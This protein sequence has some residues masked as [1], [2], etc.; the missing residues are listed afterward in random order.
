MNLI[1]AVLLALPLGGKVEI[2]WKEAYK[3]I[4]PK[5]GND[6][7]GYV[8]SSN[9]D[10]DAV[11]FDWVEI[12]STGTNLNLSD[13][14]SATVT[15]PFVFKLYDDTTSTIHVQSNGG[16]TFRDIKL[17]YF[18][19]ALPDTNGTMIAVYWSDQ[20]PS[21]HGGVYY[22]AFSDTMAVI[23]WYQVPEYSGTTYNTYEV[24]LWSDGRIRLQYLDINDYSDETVGI[25]SKDAFSTGNGWFIQYV[26]DSIPDNHVPTDSSVIE[27]YPPV[28][29]DHDVGILSLTTPSVAYPSDTVSITATVKN[30]GLNQETFDVRFI[31]DTN[32]I[33][34]LD[35]TVT[36]ISLD[37]AQIT[38]V[39]V[40]YAVQSSGKYNVM[41]YT[42]LTS[43]TNY[44][45]DTAYTSFDAIGFIPLPYITDFESDS[46]YFYHN[47][48]N[49]PWQW[50]AASY[51]HSG[52]HA[53]ATA[54]TDTYPSHGDATLYTYVIDLS[55]FSIY[56]S[57]YVRFW[58]FDSL[59]TNYDYVY[60]LITDDRGNTW[61]TLRTYNGY[62]DN[63]RQEYIDL[64]SY[65]GKKVQ[66]A[67][68]FE[69]DYSLTRAGFFLDDFEIG[70]PFDNDVGIRDININPP[71]TRPNDTVE[72]NIFVH[73]FG[74]QTQNDFYT[75]Y[76]INGPGGVLL[77]D[78]A[79]ITS[80]SPSEDTQVTVYFSPSDT[81]TYTVTAYTQ[82]PTDECTGND[83]LQANFLS[84][85]PDMSLDKHTIGGDGIASPGENN[86]PLILE[87]IN[88]GARADSV[89]FELSTT[90][91][92]ISIIDP[93]HYIGQV[94]YSDTVTDT[95]FINV[96]SSAQNGDV[97]DFTFNI[98]AE[99]NYQ[100]SS[101]F[102]IILGG[103]AWTVMVLING[104]NNLTSYGVSDI[105]EMESIGSNDYLNI[106]V[107]FDG[108]SSYTDSAGSHQDANRYYIVH[109]STP[110]DMID[111]YPIMNLG[112]VD[113]GDT[114]VIFDFFK[115]G[116]DNYPA[117][118][119]LFI[120]WDH[121]SGWVKDAAVHKG[122]SHDDT[123]GDYLSFANGEVRALLKKMHDYLGRNVDILGYDVCLVQM[124]ENLYEVYGYA[125]HVVASEKPEPG[126]GWDYHFLEAIAS[127]PNIT[128]SELSSEIVNYYSQ[129]YSSHSDVTLSAIQL[130]STIQKLSGLL[131]N[132]SREL[133]KAGGIGRS[134]IQNII[135]NLD[136]EVESNYEPYKYFVDVKHFAMELKNAGINTSI[137]SICDSIIALY[138]SSAFFDNAWASSDVS[139]SM[140]G[141]SIMLPPGG[142][143]L[144]GSGWEA[145]YSGL[146]LSGQTLWYRFLMGATAL[147]DTAH[148]VLNRG[149]F[150]VQGNITDTLTENSQ[151]SLHLLISNYTN[152]PD[153]NITIIINA[154]QFITFSSETVNIP[155][156]PED[157]TTEIELPFTISPQAT[158]GGYNVEITINGASYS[159]NY[160][161]PFIIGTITTIA[162]KNNTNPLSEFRINTFLKAGTLLPVQF[163]CLKPGKVSISLFDIQG[164]K[165]KTLFE[166]Q[167][168]KGTHSVNLK[169]PNTLS[170]G[171]YFV[172]L[173]EPATTKSQRVIILK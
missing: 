18:N 88:N 24:I 85:G 34:I 122:V 15:L 172:I 67:F 164:R 105:D 8:Y 90:S 35:T 95:F 157:T 173:K 7:Y 62:A 136:G 128:P 51:V 22:Q 14:D 133:I 106:L 77:S 152:A 78:T 99:N 96:S 58:Y 43:D 70:I 104:D 111:A 158:K 139:S 21:S 169:L 9:Q 123:D 119:Y 74:L 124:L 49:D 6:V 39:S 161:V 143:G 103:K 97:A 127:N 84:G 81:G 29:Q 33:V 162:E 37:T 57:T 71:V 154:P 3:G 114:N 48:T 5:G 159:D 163:S 42:I 94:L 101:N 1:I 46:G 59:E 38:D 166:G 121:G 115:W 23:E 112:E 113:M 25:Q 27:F 148:S 76:S 131:N 116:V 89:T 50:G 55:S 145:P 134:D 44:L 132:L 80:L 45:N 93:S 117:R 61:D 91:P 108:S 19:H 54:L 146:L 142:E 138:D 92:N 170:E 12:S 72:I 63:W 150:E 31:V 73:N 13:E 60:L 32:S 130:N 140:Y 66:L 141:I 82:L 64:K 52:T 2:P 155:V 75:I 53:W 102:Q 10:G 20:N 153:T 151:G 135:N 47:G 168:Q 167:L 79:L 30:Y 147:S 109:N 100:S 86:V 11:T 137:T 87:V 165:V 83:T 16:I 126:D 56:D 125:D 41:A 156:I 40:S 65:N 110:N 160:R 107:Q 171:I 98:L 118:H 68:K 120:I 17:S 36:S 26:Y 69:S 149:Y 129:Y 4:T 144:S 28:P